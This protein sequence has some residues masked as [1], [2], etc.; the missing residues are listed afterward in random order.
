MWKKNKSLQ[1]VFLRLITDKHSEVVLELEYSCLN[2]GHLLPFDIPIPA[3]DRPLL[4]MKKDCRKRS[5]FQRSSYSTGATAFK[6]AVDM[7]EQ[8]IPP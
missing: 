7:F 6:T 1:V 5:H 3:C 4:P 8:Q 2:Y